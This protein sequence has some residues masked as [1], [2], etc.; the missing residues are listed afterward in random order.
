MKN[1]ALSLLSIAILIACDKIKEPK[2]Q[3][4]NSNP[5]PVVVDTASDAVQ[6]RKALIVDFTG[7]KCGNCPDAHRKADELKG[8]YSKNVVVVAAHVTT[9]FAAPNSGGTKY[10]KDYRTI[11]GNLFDI[12]YQLETRGLPIGWAN[13]FANTKLSLFSTWQTAISNMVSTP[14]SVNITAKQVQV[15]NNVLTANI[16]IKANKNLDDSLNYVV[17]LVEDSIV[18]WQKDY[19]LPTNEDVQFYVHNHVLRANLTNSYGNW[20][21]NNE[22]VNDKQSFTYPIS[23]TI[24]NTNINQNNLQLVV[25][26]YNRGSGEVYQALESKVEK[27]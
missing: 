13:Q 10:R 21:N 7:F 11:A 25:F 23:Y 20:I 9:T 18:D 19:S 14:A 12:D 22:I 16:T 1:I 17:L 3:N 4:Y 2:Q 5:T 8:V 26:V 24:I 15:L 6:L 27:K